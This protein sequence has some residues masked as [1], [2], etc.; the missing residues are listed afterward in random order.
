METDLEGDLALEVDTVCFLDFVFNFEEA[1]DFLEVFL[2][3]EL[4]SSLYI[5][6]IFSNYL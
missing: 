3:F 5:Y 6:R 2:G 4:S 1:D